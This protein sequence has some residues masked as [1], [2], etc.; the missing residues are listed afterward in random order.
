MGAAQRRD[1]TAMKLE[2][3]ESSTT[4]GFA[5][6]SIGLETGPNQGMRL[7]QPADREV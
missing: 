2:L 1:V 4:E 6:I 5:F 3:S 7:T